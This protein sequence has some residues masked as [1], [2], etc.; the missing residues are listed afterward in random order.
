MKVRIQQRNTVKSNLIILFLEPD[1]KLNLKMK[2]KKKKQNIQNMPLL[3]NAVVWFNELHIERMTELTSFFLS[4]LFFFRNWK[5]YTLWKCKK[6]QTICTIVCN[7]L[8]KVTLNYR[9]WFKNSTSKYMPQITE[10]RCLHKT[11]I[12]M[13]RALLTLI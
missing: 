8:K 5:H 11:C 10:N 12:W 2:W 4:F 3:L 6:V 7:F 13:F 9:V 1:S